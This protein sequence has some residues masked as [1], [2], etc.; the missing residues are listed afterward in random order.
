[1]KAVRR[2]WQYISDNLVDCIQHICPLL[3]STLSTYICAPKNGR[4]SSKK[5]VTD[6]TGHEDHGFSRKQ[7]AQTCTQ[8]S[9]VLMAVLGKIGDPQLINEVKISHRAKNFIII[10]QQIRWFNLSF[11]S[12]TQVHLSPYT[13]ENNPQWKGL[14]VYWQPKCKIFLKRFLVH[15]NRPAVLNNRTLCIFA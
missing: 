5:T 3:Q 12:R 15:Y 13:D 4:P 10:L 7:S 11:K 1:M 2:A 8:I 6:H 14:L 9:N